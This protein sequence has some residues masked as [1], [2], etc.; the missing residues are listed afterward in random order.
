M[1]KRLFFVLCFCVCLMLLISCRTRHLTASGPSTNLSEEDIV[2]LMKKNQFRFITLSLKFNAEV[3]TG[4]ENNSF[5]GNIYI[6]KD[7]TIWISVQKLGLEAFRLLIT[8]DSV[9]MLDRINKVYIAGD[10]FVLSQMLKSNFDFDILQAL[11]TGNDTE[12]YTTTGF[13]TKKENDAYIL[14]HKNRKKQSGGSVPDSMNQEI[15]A[16][17]GDFK[18][19]KNIMKKETVDGTKTIEV[20]YSEFQDFEGQKFPQKIDFQLIDIKTI[21]ASIVFTRITPEKKESFP[22]SIPATYTLKN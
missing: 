13:V 5:S 7:S 22:F 14:S 16:R 4:E 19:V 1:N 20:S 11:F 21:T 10:Y 15:W 3:Q 12:Q 6:V 8:P 18:I 9:K 2:E 17:D